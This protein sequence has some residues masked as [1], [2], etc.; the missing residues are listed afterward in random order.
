MFYKKVIVMAQPVIPAE[1]APACFRQGSGRECI[2]GAKKAEWLQV[3]FGWFLLTFYAPSFGTEIYTWVDAKK[4]T[5][6]SQFPPEGQ[7]AN[8]IPL[9]YKPAKSALGAK[10][11]MDILRKESE[12]TPSSESTLIPEKTSDETAASKV[13][14]EQVAVHL[15]CEKAKEE[16]AFLQSKSTPEIT[17]ASGDIRLLTQTEKKQRLQTATTELETYCY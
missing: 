10:T 3:I 16:L 8:K 14:E 9:H 1:P 7:N 11:Q 6:F 4:V 17:G 15:R 12:G 5:H 2:G 13:K